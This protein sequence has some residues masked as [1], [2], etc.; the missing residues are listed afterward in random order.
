MCLY[1]HLTHV[2]VY[3]YIY[4]YTLYIYI[5]HHDVNCK[6]SGNLRYIYMYVRAPVHCNRNLILYNIH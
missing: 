2:Y 5:L 1:V 4:I 3:V 6:M